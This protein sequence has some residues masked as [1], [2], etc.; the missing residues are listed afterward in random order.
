MTLLNEINKPVWHRETTKYSAYCLTNHASMDSSFIV[1]G[2]VCKINRRITL[3][4]NKDL[5]WLV[6]TGV[7]CWPCHEGYLGR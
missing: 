5:Q 4:E 6:G 7:F 3:R 1:T 2:M